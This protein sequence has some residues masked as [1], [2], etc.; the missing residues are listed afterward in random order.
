M[1]N[2]FD[3]LPRRCERCKKWHQGYKTIMPSMKLCS[4]CAI[5]V[6][7]EDGILDT[8]DPRCARYEPV[9]QEMLKS[10]LLDKERHDRMVRNLTGAARKTTG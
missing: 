2:L 3:L 9:I 10:G 1:A 4:L 7:Y 8:N 6:L 5:K